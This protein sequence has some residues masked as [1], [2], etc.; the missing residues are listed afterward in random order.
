MFKGSKGSAS[1]PSISLYVCERKE[2]KDKT[3][4]ER[5]EQTSKTNRGSL[6]NNQEKEALSPACAVLTPGPG[7]ASALVAYSRAVYSHH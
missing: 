2:N 4:K 3:R 1:T 7:S 5:V 6:Q